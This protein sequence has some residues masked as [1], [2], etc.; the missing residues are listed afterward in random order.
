M[1]LQELYRPLVERLSKLLVG[2]AL[3]RQ[4]LVLTMFEE[5]LTSFVIY[6]PIIEL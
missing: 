6:L 2:E 1:L 4:L 5:V 3:T